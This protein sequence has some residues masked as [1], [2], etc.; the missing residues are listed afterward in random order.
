MCGHLARESSR[1]SSVAGKNP[2]AFDDIGH[3]NLAREGLTLE[4]SSLGMCHV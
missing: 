4:A 3:F 1:D 2:K